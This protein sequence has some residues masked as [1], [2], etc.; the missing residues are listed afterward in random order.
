MLHEDSYSEEEEEEMEDLSEAELIKML[1]SMEDPHTTCSRV[2]FDNDSQG[3]LT[4]LPP[5]VVTCL[6]RFGV[7]I[8]DG[9]PGA[10]EAAMEL[11]K[12]ALELH[13]K[14]SLMVAGR[15]GDDRRVRSDT[16]IWLCCPGD[17]PR[18]T[19]ASM[20]ALAANFFTAMD[21]DVAS[22]SGL[23]ASERQLARYARGPDVG[24][25]RHRD[26][27][28]S[29][30]PREE[31]S[32]DDGGVGTQRCVTAILYCVDEDWN[33]ED[34]GGRLKAWL[35]KEA[36]KNAMEDRDELFENCTWHLDA[37][38]GQPHIEVSPA[39]GRVLLFLSG[40]VDH[41]VEALRGSAE[42]RVAGTTWYH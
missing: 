2:I 17:K 27:L 26:A 7:C 21:T 40:S 14:G 16:V 36:L 20:P 19:A 12:L 13:E 31:L 23:T 9:L 24:Y 28:P 5:N 42:F 8:C 33:A 15:E 18:E 37:E 6:R 39:A 4:V 11:R 1:D 41:E 34:K 30:G 10:H 3:S 29:K 38:G 35:S 22:I 32:P 25:Q